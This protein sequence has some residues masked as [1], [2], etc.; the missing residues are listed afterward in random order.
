MYQILRQSNNV[1]AFYDSFCN[2]TKR[3]RKNEEIKLILRLVQYILGMSGAI[4]LKFGMYA[5]EGG[6]RFHSKTHLMS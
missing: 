2:C 5:T 4:L 3:Q 6:G 1:F